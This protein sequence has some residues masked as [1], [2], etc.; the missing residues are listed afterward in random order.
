[1]SLLNTRPVSVDSPLMQGMMSVCLGCAL[2]YVYSG[3]SPVYHLLLIC[4][5]F[6]SDLSVRLSD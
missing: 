2:L 5:I 3:R 6:A 4:I 1:M